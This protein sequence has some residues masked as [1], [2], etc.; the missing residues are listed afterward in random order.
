MVD[1]PEVNI[2]ALD[3]DCDE[4]ATP[5]FS[6]ENRLCEVLERVRSKWLADDTVGGT[7]VKSWPEDADDKMDE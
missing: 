7:G 1:L 2:A 4:N 5:P 3:W 6:A